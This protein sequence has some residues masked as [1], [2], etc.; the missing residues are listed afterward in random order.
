MQVRKGDNVKKKKI[1]MIL[2]YCLIIVALIT[3]IVFKVKSL[4][5][6][7][8]IKMEELIQEEIDEIYYNDKVDYY[9]YEEVNNQEYL[10]SLNE[11]KKSDNQ[12]NKKEIINTKD[13]KAEKQVTT[14]TSVSVN[15][16]DNTNATS[17]EQSSVNNTNSQEQ[18]INNQEVT[19]PQQSEHVEDNSVDTNSMDYRIHKGRIDC[20]SA[21][22]CMD[23]SI[24]IQLKFKKSISNVNYIEVISKSDKTL[25]YFID[26]VFVEYNYGTIDKCNEIGNSI[27]S[28]L[29]DRVTGFTCN[30]EGILKIS[31]DY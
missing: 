24:P 17:Q 9:T 26:Y 13:Y 6:E 28:R 11:E 29:S 21:E 23:I 12:S 18:I 14:N 4:K 1:I 5:K 20:S 19:E 10:D 31:K 2:L 3:T 22:A 27:K 15:N 16:E 25:G 8:K 7:S 30:P